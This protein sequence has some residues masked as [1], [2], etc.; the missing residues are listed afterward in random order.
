MGVRQEGANV[1]SRQ[2]VILTVLSSLAETMK[3]ESAV[4]V[5]CLVLNSCSNVCLSSKVSA[6]QIFI[7]L[8][9]PALTRIHPLGEYETLRTKWV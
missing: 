7:V 9:Q 5:S 2:L 4:T 6:S 3:L 8:S 1:N